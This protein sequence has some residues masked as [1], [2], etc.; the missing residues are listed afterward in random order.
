MRKPNLPQRPAV[1]PS[2]QHMTL[3][4]FAEYGDLL[5]PDPPLYWADAPRAVRWMLVPV[6]AAVLRVL[7]L[8]CV[9]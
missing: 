1:S 5:D 3:S 8:P 6:S 2:E 9:R 4:W 7:A